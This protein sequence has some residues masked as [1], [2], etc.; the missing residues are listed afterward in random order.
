[1]KIVLTTFI[2]LAVFASAQKPY[3]ITSVDQVCGEESENSVLISLDVKGE[4][5][6]SFPPVFD[7]ILKDEN[8]KTIKGSCTFEDTP[9]PEYTD[10]EPDDDSASEEKNSKEINKEET[11]SDE[12]ASDE[13]T[14]DELESDKN[15]ELENTIETLEQTNNLEEPENE[16][17]T[18]ESTEVV[19][20]SQVEINEISP[21]GTKEYYAYCSFE[22]TLEEGTYTLELEEG[23]KYKFDE[24][25]MEVKVHSCDPDYLNATKRADI[26]L[27]FRQVSSFDPKTF[28]FMF[29]ALTTEEIKSDYSFILM[30]YLMSGLKKLPDQIKATCTIDKA[31]EKIEEDLGIAP[32]AFKCEFPKDLTGFD[33][34]QLDY[35]SSLVSG[36]PKNDTLLNPK[37]VDEAIEKELLID[38]SKIE[39]VPFIIQLDEIDFKNVETEGT[40]ELTFPLKGENLKEGQSFEI[41]LA[42][43]SGVILLCTIEEIKNK[44]V[45]VKFEVVGKVEKQKL[46]FEQ[47]VVV[48]DGVELFVLPG[49]IS[50][51]ITTEGVKQ[52]EDDTSNEVS[53]ENSD[54]NSDLTD[55]TENSEAST[56]EATDKSAEATSETASDVEIPVDEKPITKEEALKKAEIAISFRQLSGFSFK[57]GVISFNFF[58]LTTEKL[59]KGSSIILLI[60]LIGKSG[61]KEEATEITCT[62]QENVEPKEGKSLQA[63]YKCELSGLDQAEEYTSIRLNSSEEIAGIPTDDETLL[64]PVLTEEAI[65]NEE[66]KDCSKDSSVPQTFVFESLELGECAKDGKFI[67]KGSLSEGKTIAANKISI[68]LTYPEG[69]TITCSLNEENLECI[70]DRELEE[71]I[72]IEQ[73]IINDG[74][75]ELFILQNITFDGMKCNNGLLLKAEEKKNIP[76]SFR[77]VSHIEKITNGLGFF[78]AA[79][80]NTNLPKAYILEM[81]VIV[82][83]NEEK[84]SKIANCTLDKEVTTSGTPVQGDFNCIVTLDSNETVSPEDLVISTNNDHIGGC[85]ELTK[86]E[87][88][89]QLTDEAIKE[90]KNSPELGK[91]IDYSLEENK[92]VIPPSF[93]INNLFMDR[94]EKKGKLKVTGKFSEKIENEVTFEI[95]FSYPAYKIKCKVDSAEKDKEIDIICKMQKTKKHIGFKS[96]ILEP[97]LLKKK[98]KEM[99]YIKSYQF[100]GTKEYICQNF[101]EIK[102]KRAKERKNAKFAFLQIGRPEKYAKLFYMALMKKKSEEVFKTQTFKVSLTL[103]ISKLRSLQTLDLS[104]EIEL[105]CTVGNTV[106]NA[107]ALDCSNDDVTGEPKTV[108]IEDN[109]ISGADDDVTVET[110]PNP[111]YSKSEELEKVN[112][113][114]SVTITNIESDSCSTTGKYKITATSDDE[115]DFT[116]KEGITIPFS[117]PDSSGLC[118]IEV[119]GKTLTMNCENKESF[120][121]TEIIIP[122]QVINDNDGV[123]PIFKIKEDFTSPTQFSCEISDNSLNE[124]STSTGE[125][126]ENG[127]RLYRTGSSGGLAGGAIAAIVISCVAVVA[128][129]AGIILFVKKGS[130]KQVMNNSLDN[131]INKFAL[132]EQNQYKV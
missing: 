11:S 71:T 129:V 94:C 82:I 52:K 122:S 15:V 24:E 47:T 46:I 23:T 14:S 85:S 49:F 105:S 66:I 10:E 8:D 36:L 93:E 2:L 84:V 34:I 6:A 70:A 35:N 130:G 80:V 17:E 19:A 1:M 119:S 128:I 104:D 12:H 110:E 27:S 28:S 62:L 102:L 125:N 63:N 40:F 67:I 16:E 81:N 79:F 31:V 99:F 7:L 115:I 33:S 5:K 101:N 112:N 68:P 89:P 131:T 75:E 92:K 25:N 22:Q 42:Y 116:S 30:I 65:A 86:Q 77:Q 51:A 76:I 72:V 106:G 69:T 126:A 117:N 59:T 88:S 60:N 124:T 111:D 43:P 4:E 100:K 44:E 21:V 118:K 90:S 123:T 3:T 91:V 45:T 120:S 20:S 64:N 108:D 132:N 57:G 32:A 97:R 109:Q 38:I 18:E 29:F 96:F 78:F 95:P 13:Q 103:L 39:T 73:T 61:M 26:T 107:G 87:A 98:K 37:L 121:A 55:T 113:L 58:A 56:N 114:P 83:I 54:E 50:K 9:S 41:N 74:S 48:V 127:S 53:D